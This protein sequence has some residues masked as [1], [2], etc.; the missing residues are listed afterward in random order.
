MLGIFFTERCNFT[1]QNSNYLAVPN[2]AMVHKSWATL[3]C[4]VILLERYYLLLINN[5]S[6]VELKVHE[7]D[8]RTPKYIKTIFHFFV[9][10]IKIRNHCPSLVSAKFTTTPRRIYS[11]PFHV[12][13]IMAHPR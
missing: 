1:S 11:P 13:S 9:N 6:F 7:K 2:S 4:I 10:C 3:K 5:D 12:K 8:K